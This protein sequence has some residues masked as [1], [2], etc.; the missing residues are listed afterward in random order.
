MYKERVTAQDNKILKS[1]RN[2][3]KVCGR[4]G[5]LRTMH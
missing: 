5:I 1:L 4:G 2:K 3:G